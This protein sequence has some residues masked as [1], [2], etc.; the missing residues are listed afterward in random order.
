MSD[1]EAIQSDYA[2]TMLE[3]ITNNKVKKGLN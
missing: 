2:Y 3:A 1:I